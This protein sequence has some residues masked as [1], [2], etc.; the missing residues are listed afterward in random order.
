MEERSAAAYGGEGSSEDEDL[1]GEGYEAGEL[2]L[3]VQQDDLQTPLPRLEMT[4][5]RKRMAGEGMSLPVRCKNKSC[6]CQELNCREAGEP[7][8]CIFCQKSQKMELCHRKG[9]CQKWTGEQVR[10]MEESRQIQGALLEAETMNQILIP[11]TSSL[12][13][14]TPARQE[15]VGEATEMRIMVEVEGRT[16][17]KPRVFTEKK[18]TG[19]PMSLA[20]RPFVERKE[21]AGGY[22]LHLDLNQL[23]FPFKP[24]EF[25]MTTKGSKLI[26]NAVHQPVQVGAGNTPTRGGGAGQTYHQEFDLPP[27]TANMK[28]S[29]IITPDNV[30]QLYF[31]DVD[32]RQ[33][34]REEEKNEEAKLEEVS[35]SMMERQREVVG[36]LDG[37]AER[38]KNKEEQEAKEEW[39]REKMKKIAEAA[40]KV[41]ELQEE[42]EESYREDTGLGAGAVSPERMEEDERDQEGKNREMRDR[43][44]RARREW[45]DQALPEF[46]GEERSKTVHW[47]TNRVAEETFYSMG[48]SPLPVQ[49]LHTRPGLPKK[50]ILQ[51]AKLNYLESLKPWDRGG[52]MFG[53]VSSMAAPLQQSRPPPRTEASTPPHVMVAAPGHPSALST[54][55]RPPTTSQHT[56]P[57]LTPNYTSLDPP[58]SSQPRPSTY[59]DFGL[60]ARAREDW[61]GRGQD[62]VSEEMQREGGRATEATP[63]LA[64]VLT[65]LTD[66]LTS[67]NNQNTGRSSGLKLPT[68]SLPRCKYDSSH[69]T[70]ARQWYAFK[71]ALFNC[72]SQH[73][74]DTRVLLMHY[75]SDSRLLPST[76]QEAFQNSESLE[77]ALEMIDS[78]FPPLN[79]LHAEL[80]KEILSYP[81][82]EAV[83][84]KAKILRCS[85]LLSSLEDFLRFFKGEASLDLSRDKL[86]FILH[87]L[88]GQQE[89]KQE[90]L[91]EVSI[92]DEKRAEGQLYAESLK[93]FLLRY[94]LLYVDLHSAL[95]LVGNH[96]NSSKHRSAATKTREK[97]AQILDACALCQGAH[98]VW[99]CSVE[100]PKIANGS[101]KLPGQICAACLDVKK[102]GHPQKCSIVRSKQKG[103]YY[104]YQNLCPRC[105]I[106]LK[107]CP[108]PEKAQKKVDPDQSDAPTKTR[109]AAFRVKIIPDEEEEDGPEEVAEHIHAA[110]SAAVTDDLKQNVVFLSEEILVLGKENQTRRIVLSYDSHSSSHHCTRDIGN[111]FNWNK[112]GDTRPVSMLTVA[113]EMTT[114]MLIFQVKILTLQ[115]ILEVTALEGTWTDSK[116]EPQLDPELAREC[117]VALPCQGGEEAEVLPRLILGC[118]E[119]TRFPRRQPTPA[120]LAIRHPKMAVFT[121]SLSGSQLACGQLGSL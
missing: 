78:R 110:F 113:G 81:P 83:T 25:E 1:F 71:H 7:Q 115:G 26:V 88:A 16:G 72:V 57:A 87:N 69:Q 85:K 54:P 75:A 103:V 15:E 37:I 12:P 43:W 58:I 121:S 30:A 48:D 52:N 118:A 97:P 42:L 11:A 39:R 9:V 14:Q 101:R 19:A 41:A 120:R 109:S 13:P 114:Q 46:P 8:E 51:P 23:S 17:A 106:N 44:E 82:L 102:T 99:H 67:P 33:K 105:S 116:S 107:I 35:P 5:N 24:E 112:E 74:L 86:L 6:Q 22:Q 92:M 73:Q 38:A 27:Q 93:E 79:S 49:N 98:R 55:K 91:R 80:V 111:D 20:A 21:E 100:L 4:R 119:I 45:R 95:T 108:C 50:S 68:V 90:V 104:L 63:Q 40:I 96:Q 18:K 31:G 53:R 10:Q 60:A 62:G 36:W 61:R 117:N 89:Y 3:V 47:P 70:T 66:R 32:V 76:M 59:P 65:L 94:R 64:E 77:K 84:E 56:S 28:A 29:C 2:A 34:E